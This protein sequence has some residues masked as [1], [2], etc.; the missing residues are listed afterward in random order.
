MFSQNGRHL[1]RLDRLAKLVQ[2]EEYVRPRV[3]R[4]EQLQ[5][6]VDLTAV[7]AEIGGQGSI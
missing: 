7:A 1:V 2:R 3:D 4:L 5:V 6:L